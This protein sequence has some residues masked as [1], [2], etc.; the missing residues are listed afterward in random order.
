MES[1]PEEQ[2]HDRVRR[3][4]DAIQLKVPDRVPIFTS[5]ATFQLYYVGMTCEDAY[6]NPEKWCDATKQTVL[7]FQPDMYRHNITSGYIHEYLEN[8]QYKLPGRGA[9]PNSTHQFVEAEYMKADEYTALL[10]D[11]VDYTIRTYMPR[12]YGALQPFAELPPLT[13]CLFGLSIAP[14]L[15]KPEIVAAFEA[16]VQ[17]GR[18]MTRVAT[19]VDAFEREMVSLG[20]P[21]VGRGGTGAPFDFISDFLRGMHGSM[22]DM[23]RQPEKLIDVQEQILELRIQQGVAAVKR[24]EN[25]RV[26][27]PLH[28]G[29]DGFMSP[30][31]FETFYWPGLKKA[32]CAL[33]DAGITPFIFFE[34]AYDQRLEYLRELPRGKIVAQFDKTD[35]ARAKDI[36]GDTI[37]ILGNMPSS[38][39]SVGTPR[40]VTAYA[41]QLIDVVGE[42]GGYIMAGGY[43]LT[44]ARPD[45]V[46]VWI[47][48]SKKYGQYSK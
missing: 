30:K 48:F 33:V 22:L 10:S 5:L 31:Q 14:I 43:S 35:M 32:I 39:L 40:Q 37:C 36:L 20:F 28:R 24:G 45:L 23:Y 34:G 17:A 13:T 26:F 19:L 4:E 1:S 18:E 3:I 42:G 46:K 7:A 2:Y 47:D 29:A 25:P 12:V 8:R 41:K 11:P 9:P 6:F 16:L 15:A 21:A 38:L 27:V 44:E